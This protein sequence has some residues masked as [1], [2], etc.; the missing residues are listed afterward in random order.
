M[1]IS[2]SDAGDPGKISRR[3]VDIPAIPPVAAKVLHLLN[4]E[5]AS[6]DEL[7]N[8]ISLE[9]AFAAKVLKIAN[10][11]FYGRSI[12]K[13]S[14]A[15]ALVGFYAT[16][17]LLMRISL[18][19]MYRRRHPLENMLWEHS[20]GVSLA[21]SL[22]AARTNPA[23][24]DEALIAGL[25]H[26]IGKAVLSHSMQDVYSGIVESAFKEGRSFIDA[27]NARLGYNHCD[28]GKDAAKAW[29]LPESLEAAITYHHAKEIPAAL[30]ASSGDICGIVRIADA[31]CIHSGIGTKSPTVAD[32][33]DLI[34][35]GLTEKDV[36]DIE[37]EL[38]E[39]YEKQRRQFQD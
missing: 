9:Q 2:K 7:E 5:N 25:L 10:S 16:A 8:I 38:K 4:N 1:T 17:S 19:D 35:S 23:K 18:R 13:I 31:L 3:E 30:S 26:D 21:S 11:P 14:E 6:I 20:L 29:N 37:E 32:P 15:V 24:R 34:I 28:I 12:S 39:A 36:K 22:I 27:E 33:E